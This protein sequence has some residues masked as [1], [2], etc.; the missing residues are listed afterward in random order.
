MNTPM[1]SG[2]VIGGLVNLPGQVNRFFTG[3]DQRFGLGP[4]NRLNQNQRIAMAD[5]NINQALAAR[6]FN[7][8][9]I[10]TMKGKK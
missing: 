3:V 6:R 2:N 10:A 7:K 1:S 8:S 5:G 9:G 4:Q